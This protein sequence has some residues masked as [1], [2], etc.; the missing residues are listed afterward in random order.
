MNPVYT[1][2][3]IST[4]CCK[5]KGELSVS[6]ACGIYYSIYKTYAYADII[7]PFKKKSNFWFFMSVSS[8]ANAESGIRTTCD[9]LKLLTAKNSKNR[10]KL[11]HLSCNR[12]KKSYLQKLARI[13]LDCLDF[14]RFERSSE[15]SS[16]G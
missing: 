13:F 8:G 12:F 1:Y 3:K 9:I 14:G 11:R 7:V 6:A 4:E 10:L 2:I 16:F 5:E 15:Q